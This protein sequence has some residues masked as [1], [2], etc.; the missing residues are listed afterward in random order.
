MQQVPFQTPPPP[1]PPPPEVAAQSRLA[2]LWRRLNR[3]YV[4][5]RYVFLATAVALIAL[6]TIVL[7]DLTREAPQRLTQRDIDFAVGRA[8]ESAAPG[9]SY[10]S[11]AYQVIRPS[12]V[13][14]QVRSARSDS[15]TEGNLGSGFIVDETGIILTI[16]ISQST[17]KTALL[18]GSGAEYS[19]NW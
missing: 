7:Y 11:Q 15:A 4:R 1:P 19:R 2:V 16:P 8:L 14:V 9:P 10:A 18:L 12:L 17:P 3:V 13:Q 5:Y 6:A